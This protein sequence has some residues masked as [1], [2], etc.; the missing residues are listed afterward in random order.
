M[1]RSYTSR[2][3]VGATENNRAGL[4]TARHVMCLGCGVDDLV[5]GL[6]G[7]VKRHEPAHCQLMYGV[8]ELED[9][10][11]TRRQDGGRPKLRQRPNHRIQIR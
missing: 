2:K 8:S 4:D 9:L 6:H 1:L 3:S 7:E 10:E 5:N 11:R